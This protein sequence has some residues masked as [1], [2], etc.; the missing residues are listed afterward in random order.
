MKYQLMVLASRSGSVTTCT[1]NISAITPSSPQQDMD[2][3]VVGSIGN[4]KA[5]KGTP[6]PITQQ[7]STKEGS[8]K[9]SNLLHIPTSGESS[10]LSSNSSN[11]SVLHGRQSRSFVANTSD[12][13]MS[14]NV[15]QPSPRAYNV[16]VVVIPPSQ[17]EEEEPTTEQHPVCT[18]SETI[19]NL[20]LSGQITS[21]N[22]ATSPPH[23]YQ[24]KA[25][26]ISSPSQTI[27]SYAEQPMDICNNNAMLETEPYFSKEDNDAFE[28]PKWQQDLNKEQLLEEAAAQSETSEKCS[29]SQ[30]AEVEV[31]R[32]TS[33][34]VQFQAWQT[35]PG[36]SIL[37]GTRSRSTSA[38]KSV[39]PAPGIQMSKEKLR[40][41]EISSL[42]TS[43]ASRGNPAKTRCA[44]APPKKIIPTRLKGHL[45]EPADTQ[46]LLA[47]IKDN[48]PKQTTDDEIIK[49]QAASLRLH[50]TE[51][52]QEL[53]EPQLKSNNGITE[54]KKTR[55]GA[56]DVMMQEQSGGEDLFD[57]ENND[58]DDEPQIAL[59]SNLKDA[60]GDQSAEMHHGKADCDV[61]AASQDWCLHYLTQTQ[62]D[63]QGERLQHHEAVE[64]SSKKQG[65][66]SEISQSV[67]QKPQKVT[68]ES[69]ITTTSYLSPVEVCSSN[70]FVKNSNNHSEKE[71]SGTGFHFSLPKENSLKPVSEVI[72]G[73]GEIIKKGLQSPQHHSTPILEKEESIKH[74]AN[75]DHPTTEI[76]VEAANEPPAASALV[77]GK[78]TDANTDNT[79]V[80]H[81]ARPSD[82]GEL[83]KIAK[84]SPKKTNSVFSKVQQA[85]E[86]DDCLYDIQEQSS[87]SCHHTNQRAVTFNDSNSSVMSVVSDKIETLSYSGDTE[88][89][90]D[91][92]ENMEKE[93]VSLAG[94]NNNKSSGIQDGV[95]SQ[96]K[97]I[98]M[99]KSVGRGVQQSK[100]ASSARRHSPRKQGDLQKDK[101]DPFDFSDSQC[102]GTPTQGRRQQHASGESVSIKRKRLLGLQAGSTETRTSAKKGLESSSKKAE[103]ICITPRSTGKKNPK[104]KTPVKTS[105][106][107][108]KS[109][110][111]DNI[112]QDQ[113]IEAVAATS[114]KRSGLA[115]NLVETQSTVEGEQNNPG[116]SRTQAEHSNATKVTWRTKI[117]T[118]TTTIVHRCIQEEAVRDGVVIEVKKRTEV[119]V[120]TVK[121]TEQPEP[122]PVSPSRTTSSFSS[123]DLGDVSSL[124]TSKSS[125]G[126]GSSFSRSI[127]T[128]SLPKSSSNVGSVATGDNVRASISI[129]KLHAAVSIARLRELPGKSTKKVAFTEPSTPTCVTRT[130]RLSR[131]ISQDFGSTKNSPSNSKKLESSKGRP[132][133]SEI[134]QADTDALSSPKMLE[135]IMTRKKKNTSD[136]SISDDNKSATESGDARPDDPLGLPKNGSGSGEKHPDVSI[137][138]VT[139]SKGNSP[140]VAPTRRC[141]PRK[142]TTV[143]STE[144][145][146]GDLT[147]PP[148]PEIGPYLLPGVRVLARW[149]DG[150]YYPGAIDKEES[151]NRYSF[152]FDDGDKRVIGVQDI[153]HKAWLSKG[154][155]VLA[156]TSSELYSPG[157]VI[158][159]FRDD[160]CCGYIIESESTGESQRYPRSKVILTKE[161]AAPLLQFSASTDLHTGLNLDNIVCGKRLRGR[162]TTA[163]ESPSS[164][165]EKAQTTKKVKGSSATTPSK[166]RSRPQL[167][168]IVK[169]SGNVYLIANTYCRTKKYFQALAAGLPCIS[170]IWLRDS[171][172]DNKLQDYKSYV[173]AAGE[174]IEEEKLMECPK[175]QTVLQR[176]H[177]MVVSEQEETK[178]TWIS[179]L[180]AARCEVV[181]NLPSNKNPADSDVAFTC[182]VIVT[183][184]TCP[185]SI[186]DKAED[187]GIPVVSTEW[188]IQCLINGYRPD[189]DGHESYIWNYRQK[190]FKPQQKK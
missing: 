183:D 71:N 87:N 16:D 68:T 27:D 81:V 53:S 179:I 190:R 158:G 20:H 169:C 52:A 118:I 171:C 188:V 95:K 123:G 125:S 121:V 130:R 151:P 174:S 30:S 11:S 160:D 145:S 96:H 8:N 75:S 189:Y 83:I 141:S 84:E 152:C 78:E 134:V 44:S 109:K 66:G 85:R 93:L 15:I 111:Q 26:I 42:P 143:Q 172:K 46:Y 48:A 178:N 139:K 80:F 156:E 116:T 131:H 89:L 63:T 29:P 175:E 153:L 10:S 166:K 7:I 4:V 13:T 88:I 22:V 122:P 40:H 144:E 128:S 57:D 119:D 21:S 37:E 140:S 60:I 103:K 74:V 47:E 177:I 70:S 67:F 24:P 132:K 187:L 49:S 1:G 91:E 120:P 161:Q 51:T 114:S 159:Y 77:L 97:V 182:D 162:I 113:I 55:G 56:E 58:G 62:S 150:Y 173:L 170:H 147:D 101:R 34:S 2:P 12:E 133:R 106:V 43:S 136:E 69:V 17:E 146:S 14:D 72:P 41:K 129:P 107:K 19:A 28:I 99:Q 157:T 92:E 82:A 135:N 38:G 184:P 9:G 142:A 167:E 138:T 5:T 64:D 124:S 73:V 155:M 102:Y 110:E 112:R 36:S 108:R 154:Q 45:D 176:M 163:N 105:K 164:G 32:P 86:A 149:R 90:E 6:R 39:T 117:T 165:G 148:D 50:F 59:T 23:D 98:H 94:K 31:E 25:I 76:Q 100:S 137:N 35:S 104:R 126:S 186:R 54:I 3:A 127:S 65:A 168:E 18:P 115:K 79:P 180:H 61:V 181:S 33:H 185:K